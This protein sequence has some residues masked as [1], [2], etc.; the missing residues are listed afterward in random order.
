M[1]IFGK[2]EVKCN[3]NN[4]DLRMAIHGI[5]INCDWYLST[6]K[7]PIKL[8]PNSENPSWSIEMTLYSSVY[9]NLKA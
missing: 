3:N 7:L 8:N 5:P 9:L 1:S 6:I 4:G 2:T